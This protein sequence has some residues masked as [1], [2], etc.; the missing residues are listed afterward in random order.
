[1]LAWKTERPLLLVFVFAV[2]AYGWSL[3]CWA[4]ILGDIKTN[5]MG[6][7]PQALALFLLGGF[8]PTAAAILLSLMMGGGELKHLL[9]RIT[10]WR[11]HAGWYVL[12]LL[13]APLAAL[14][15]V[16]IYAALGGDIGAVRWD[17]WWIILA[18]YGVAIFFG[19]LLEETGWRGFAQ[20]ILF[21]RLGIFATGMVIG[22]IWTFWHTPLFFAAEGSAL[23][24][25]N[26]TAQGLAAYWAFNTGQSIIVAWMLAKARGSVLIAMLVHHG[27]NA[28]GI[29]WL[30]YDIPEADK[31]LA[32]SELAAVPIWTFIVIGL[33]FGAMRGRARG[34]AVNPHQLAA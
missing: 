31:A 28:S 23:S 33:V 34:E 11:V 30:F 27:V 14:G 17:H 19:P 25:G 26:F 21:N 20:P 15:G 18:F 6:M 32:F 16:G 2:L 4:P 8:G 13:F 24:G 7:A 12:A 29:A 9:G 10:R 1:M 3:A 22:T 5:I